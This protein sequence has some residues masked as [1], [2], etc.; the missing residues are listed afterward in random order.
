MVDSAEATASELAELLAARGMLAQRSSG[1][2]LRLLV[3]DLPKRFAEVAAR[4]LGHAV[5]DVPVEAIDL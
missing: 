2:R 3:T 1:G 5:D 4:F